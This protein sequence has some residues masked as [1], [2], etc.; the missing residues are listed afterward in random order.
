MDSILLK[1]QL[2]FLKQRGFLRIATS[3]TRYSRDFDTTS[4]IERLWMDKFSGR[5][6]ATDGRGREAY[7]W[8]D[9]N[10]PCLIP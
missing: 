7:A 6:I 10:V 8:R 2:F 9:I 1:G 5:L 4:N 3:S